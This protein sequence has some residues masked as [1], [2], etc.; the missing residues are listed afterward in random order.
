[1][2]R[3]KIGT[4]GVDAGVLMIIDP[5][6]VKYLHDLHSADTWGK[7]CEEVIQPLWQPPHLGGEI[8]MGGGGV[9]V[10]TGGDG[11]FPVYATYDEDGMITKVEVIFGE[12]KPEVR[13]HEGDP[14]VIK[15]GRSMV[16]IPFEGWEEDKTVHP[17]CFGTDKVL[18]TD[19][20]LKY[21]ADC[22]RCS[23][24]GK[25]LKEYRKRVPSE[26]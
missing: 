16:V 18:I 11:G 6:Y 23:L 1:M 2:K 10:S 26:I 9:I 4:A 3:R 7:F 20:D 8:P 21:H 15:L 25:C 17:D 22:I 14:E 5:C 13:E 19:P 24:E 12:D